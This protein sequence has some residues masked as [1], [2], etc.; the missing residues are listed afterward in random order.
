[1]AKENQPFLMQYALLLELIYLEFRK[2]QN[3]IFG[4]TKSEERNS[5]AISF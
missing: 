2:F 3:A 4:K 1:M 5:K